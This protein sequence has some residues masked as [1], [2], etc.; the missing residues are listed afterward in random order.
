M[1]QPTRCALVGPRLII[2]AALSALA[3]CGGGSAS[4]DGG[5]DGR[6]GSGPDGQS[7]VG[8][9]GRTGN[10]PDGQTGGGSCSANVPA[11]QACNTLANVGSRVT[12]T[13]GTGTMPT[14][15]G[16]TIVDGT[17][18]LTSQTYYGLASCSTET[19][20]GTIEIAG[21][22]VQIVSGAPIPAT[23]SFTIV[24]QGASLMMTE[25]CLDLGVEAGAVSPDAP[26]KTFTAT[27]T[28]F[29]LFTMNAAAGNPNPD[30]VETYAKQ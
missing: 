28:T 12:P 11:G 10:G 5:P 23:G 27:P 19:V 8:P 17:Y 22:C 25:T 20:S 15:T 4:T 18:A 9:D 2:V 3:A 21:G 14:G 30:R 1:T 6:T 16:G 7:D 24:A 29:T 26:A 13:C